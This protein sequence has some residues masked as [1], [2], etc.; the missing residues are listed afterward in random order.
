VNLNIEL[1]NGK[2][3][4]VSQNRS[5]PNRVSQNISCQEQGESEQVLSEQGESE[6]VL[7]KQ[8][9][10]ELGVQSELDKSEQRELYL[11]QSNLDESKWLSYSLRQNGVSQDWL[12]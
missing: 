3:N 9:E 11:A 7:T 2:P 1:E 10:S 6:Q 8:C 5:C 12:R 4:R